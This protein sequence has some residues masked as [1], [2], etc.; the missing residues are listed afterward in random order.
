MSA[1]L[2]FRANPVERL[3]LLTQVDFDKVSNGRFTAGVDFAFA[4]WTF[5]NKLKLRV[6]RNQLPLALY[7]E[8]YDVGTLRPFSSLS[9]SVYGGTQIGAE[10]HDGAGITGRFDLK[11]GWTLEYDAYLGFLDLKDVLGSGSQNDAGGGA[12]NS[13]DLVRV[14]PVHMAGGRVGLWTP[15]DG[16]RFT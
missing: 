15:V 16:L 7:S 6:G 4:E 1:A 13:E 10:N 11:E 12:V 8:I 5:S 2:L 3:S 9:P 14:H